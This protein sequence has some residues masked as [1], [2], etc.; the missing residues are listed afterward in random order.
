[1][2]GMFSNFRESKKKWVNLLLK[3]DGIY[4]A[5]SLKWV[6][7]TPKIDT[8]LNSLVCGDCFMKNFKLFQSALSLQTLNTS[9]TKALV[10]PLKTIEVIKNQLTRVASLQKSASINTLNTT[11]CNIFTSG[12]N[13][14]PEL[15][16]IEN[17]AK[18]LNNAVFLKQNIDEGS[19]SSDEEFTVTV[20]TL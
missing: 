19:S 14:Q 12:N 15:S 4:Y 13:K 20:K 6:L 10:A 9:N 7:S 5:G 17:K 18:T 3:S 1:M 16:Q 8:K 11:P 2:C